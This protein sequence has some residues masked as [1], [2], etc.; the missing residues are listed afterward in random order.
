M[1]FLCSGKTHASVLTMSDLILG[2]HA[3]LVTTGGGVSHLSVTQSPESAKL[4][5]VPTQENLSSSPEVWITLLVRKIVS[6]V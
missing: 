6:S 1:T 2:A 3:T 4:A 5:W